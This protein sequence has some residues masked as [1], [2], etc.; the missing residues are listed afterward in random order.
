HVDEDVAGDVGG[1]RRPRRARGAE[2]TLGD[3]PV[4]R[5]REDRAPVLELVDVAR[6]LVA[7]DL[8]RILVAEVVRAL[9]GVEGVD[10]GTVLRGV[11]EGRVDA[12]LGGARVAAD[13]VDL[14]EERDVGACVEGLDGCAHACA[15]GADDE[16][17]VLRFHR[18]G[19][20]RKAFG[21]RGSSGLAPM[22]L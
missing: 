1:I 6:R 7:E 8:D 2:G 21:R 20:Y 10:L 17:V 5:P 11:P 13:G 22:V 3:P 9:D 19:R 4:L 18:Y 14:R 12:A 16:D 15:T